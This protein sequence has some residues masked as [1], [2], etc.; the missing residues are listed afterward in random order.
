MRRTSQSVSDLLTIARISLS[1]LFAIAAAMPNGNLDHV[2]R[3][4][5]SGMACLLKPGWFQGTYY[6]YCNGKCP[7]N[8]TSGFDYSFYAR[9]IQEALRKG[10]LGSQKPFNQ[11]K[12]IFCCVPKEWSR[13]TFPNGRTYRSATSCHCA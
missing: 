11:Q 13:V 4:R 6:Q 5:R 2:S 9:T 3:V 10:L 8:V 7:R 1:V 12:W